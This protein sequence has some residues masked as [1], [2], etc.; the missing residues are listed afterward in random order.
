[1]KQ[2]NAKEIASIAIKLLI[3]C[4]VVAAIVAFVYVITKD[5]IALNEKLD[6]ASALTSIYKDDF[7]GKEFTYDEEKD[8]YVILEEAAEEA[9]EKVLEADKNE[10]WENKT[11]QKILASASVCTPKDGFKEDV[12]ALYQITDSED[13][14]MGYCVAV[15]PMGFKDVIKM[16]VAVNSDFTVKD[17]KIVSMSETSGIGTKVEEP[18]FLGQFSGKEQGEVAIVDTISGATK[19]SKPVIYGVSQSIEQVKSYVSETEVQSVE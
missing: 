13:K 7:D 4:S 14:V 15:E 12:T 9:Q 10:T 3:I 5:R 16:L 2:S 17:V 18:E 6:T 8:L 1:M 11:E 19:S